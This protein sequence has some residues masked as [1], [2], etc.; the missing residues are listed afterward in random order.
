MFSLWALQR[1]ILA[2]L[3]SLFFTKFY[4]WALDKM[5]LGYL[6]LGHGGIWIEPNIDKGVY[7]VHRIAKRLLTSGHKA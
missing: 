7:G 3:E 5:T 4:G 1:T 6:G 2:R